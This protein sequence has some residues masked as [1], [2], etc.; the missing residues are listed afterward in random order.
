[1][2]NPIILILAAVVAFFIYKKYFSNKSSYTVVSF[3]G[4]SDPVAATKLFQENQTKI[5]S[6]LSTT[7]AEAKKASKS[8]EELINITNQY[9]DYSNNLTKAFSRWAIMHG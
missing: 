2:N 6:E 3:D 7:L 1:M 5:N 4:I 9:A 8:K